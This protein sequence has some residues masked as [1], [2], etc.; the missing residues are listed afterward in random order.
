MYTIK[1]IKTALIIYYSAPAKKVF[2]Q[3]RDGVIYFAVGLMSVWMANSAMQP[4]IGQ[5]LVT[6]CGLILAGIGFIMALMAEVRMLI[7]RFIRFALK[8]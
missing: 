3:F 5:E 8:K 1:Q 4:S 2:K 6:L 7:G